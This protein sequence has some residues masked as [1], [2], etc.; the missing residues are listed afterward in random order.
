MLAC[1]RPKNCGATRPPQSFVSSLYEERSG[2][3][4]GWDG[5]VVWVL[6]PKGCFMGCVGGDGEGGRS[7]RIRR[8]CCRQLWLFGSSARVSPVCLECCHQ[9]RD[10]LVGAGVPAPLCS[11]DFVPY[12]LPPWHHFCTLQTLVWGYED[13]LGKGGL[14]VLTGEETK[15]RITELCSDWLEPFEA[16]ILFLVCFILL[17]LPLFILLIKCFLNRW[18]LA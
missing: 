7:Y 2:C 12:Q 18:F 3:F 5:T 13:I 10:S 17:N 8:T 16:H 6:G 1:L 9:P 14:H 11:R 4:P 15:V